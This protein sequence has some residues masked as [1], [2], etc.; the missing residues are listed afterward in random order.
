MK[1]TQFYVMI[2]KLCFFLTGVDVLLALR[3]LLL[4][5]SSAPLNASICKKSQGTRDTVLPPST[6]AENTLVC[7]GSVK[8]IACVL[9][10]CT[11]FVDLT[12]TW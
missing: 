11:S 2:M 10:G 3:F 8:H 5:Y 1:G 9:F 7:L 6:R 4:S 12:S